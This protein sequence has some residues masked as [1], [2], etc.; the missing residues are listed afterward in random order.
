MHAIPTATFPLITFSTFISSVVFAIIFSCGVGVSSQ[1]PENIGIPFV[2]FVIDVPA[3]VHTFVF[4]DEKE[5]V[6]G[7]GTL[8]LNVKHDEL[9]VVTGV[10]VEEGRFD[11]FIFSKPFK[12]DTCFELEHTFLD[13]ESNG[14][15]PEPLEMFVTF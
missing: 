12:V 10:T 2:V 8:G 15:A 1:L 9:L 11:V 3:V 13:D 5:K 7:T 6:V 4:T 14:D